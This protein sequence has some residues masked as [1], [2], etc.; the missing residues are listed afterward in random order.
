MKE[1]P[2]LHDKTILELKTKAANS[3]AKKLSFWSNLGK[4]SSIG[5]D[6]EKNSEKNSTV[7]D[8]ITRPSEA[9]PGTNATNNGNK[10]VNYIL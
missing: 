3:K 7:V 5:N 1:N 2:E 4:K 9:F 10:T 6:S 8:E